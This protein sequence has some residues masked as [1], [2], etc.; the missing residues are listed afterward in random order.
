MTEAAK[1]DSR[2]QLERTREVFK[3][4]L[5]ATEAAGITIEEARPG[6]ARCEMELKRHHRNA[7]GAVMG[8]AIFTLADLAGAV[9]MNCGKEQPD[10]VSLHADITFLSGAR[11]S[12][13]IAEASCVR[14]GRTTSLFDIDI[15]DELD[16]KVARVSINGFTVK[17][18]K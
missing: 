11:G 1:I 4:D 6:Y 13:L 12:R 8:G 10:T 18:D 5:F 17:K 7:M 14:A 15:K 3:G 9:A 16:T 2:E